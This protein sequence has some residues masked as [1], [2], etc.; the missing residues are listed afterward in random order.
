MSTD[1]APDT[2]LGMTAALRAG[3]VSPSELVERSLARLEAW[4]P[5]T[6]AFSQVWAGA[7]MEQAERGRPSESGLAGVPI[8]VKDLFDVAGLETTGCSRIY[9][10]RVAERDAPTIRR[11][12]DAGLVMV[13]KTN[14]HELAFGGTN[15][16]SACGRTGNPWDPT[17][18]T[19]GSS[20]GS[21][22]AVAAG[23]V[24]WA[25][26]SDTGGS[27]RI[28][29]SLCGVFGLKV[30]TGAISIEGML[31]LAPT[32][33]APGLLAAT[34]A[35]LEALYRV[36]AALPP[37][38]S[39][40]VEPP[41]R[42]E[43]VRIGLLGG[44][45]ATHVHRDAVRTVDAVAAAFEGVGANVE[46]VPGEG[47][48]QAR[49]VWRRLCAS[50]FV[51]AHPAVVERRGE[52]LDPAI[53]DSIDLALATTPE[54]LARASGRRAAIGRA[55]RACLGSGPF[56]ALLVPTTGYAA[57]PP[58][59]RT[60]PAWPTG[61]IDLDRVGPGWFTSAVNLAGLPAVSL[62]AGTSEDGMPIGASLIGP[63]GGE[64][65]LLR[66]A[67]LWEA[68]AG[69]RPPM[70]RPPSGATG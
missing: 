46:R 7:A 29:A 25:L 37:P 53:L 27:I 48:E 40:A 11:V 24:P 26:G 67:A 35:D 20:G 10:G 66:L 13:G 65:G 61:E 56:D 5:T 47:I 31:P 9:V 49:G 30:T 1:G 58:D 55:L 34:A 18:M 41:E 70:L 38:T 57:P 8:A 28:P 52:I 22:A 36:L 6:N 21:A 69:Y 60:L 44:Y 68:A 50:E 54:D 64:A 19:G 3:Q 43:G 45:F 62:P 4:Q 59:A 23:V 12:R 33:D 32:M 2:A 51:A 14:Q 39:R 15:L 42:G 63:D 17:R 16:Y